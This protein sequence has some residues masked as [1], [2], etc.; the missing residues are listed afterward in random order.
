MRSMGGPR[1]TA[2]R[3]LG[4][5]APWGRKALGV[6]EVLLVGALLPFL[7]TFLAASALAGLSLRFRGVGLRDLGG[8]RRAGST[9]QCRASPLSP[10]TRPWKASF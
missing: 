10:S 2:R 5:A 1:S 8:G 6:L 4:A 3:R 7:A 9:E